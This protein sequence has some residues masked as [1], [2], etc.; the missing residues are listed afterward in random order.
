MS[1]Y[2]KPVGDPQAT[3]RHVRG[4]VPQSHMCDPRAVYGSR[5]AYAGHM[6]KHIRYTME[7]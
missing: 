3:H 7:T 1:Q 4:T 5:A 2:D 6:Q